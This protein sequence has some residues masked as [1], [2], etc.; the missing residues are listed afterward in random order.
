[1]QAL[2]T[3]TS[4]RIEQQH[5]AGSRMLHRLL[6]FNPE[7]NL[8]RAG[9]PD[10]V[11]VEHYIAK[12]FSQTYGAHVTEFAPFLLSMRCAGNISA[13]AGIRPADSGPMFLEQYLDS[14]AEEVLSNSFGKNIARHEIFELGNLAA[15]RSG[16]CQFIYLIMAGVIARTDLSYAV[17]AGTKEVAKSVSKL[18]FQV[19]TI[20]A[21]DPARLGDAAANW[22]SYYDSEPH[23]MTMDAEKSMQTLRELSLPSI[24]LKMYEPQIDELARHINSVRRGQHS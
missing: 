18:G 5:S 23:I 20:T 1:M 4:E 21:A 24:L 13:A 6:R 14:P 17:F 15:L 9:S 19:N 8:H 10:R 16:V 3:A 11:E 12:V 2:L 7:F 22:G